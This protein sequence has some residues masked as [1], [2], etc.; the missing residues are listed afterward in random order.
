MKSRFILHTA[1]F[2]LLTSW[3]FLLPV[4][5]AD[6]QEKETLPDLLALKDKKA[7]DS[8]TPL[9]S[10]GLDDANKPNGRIYR[11]RVSI[12]DSPPAFIK[13]M[14]Q[15]MTLVIADQ[16]G[17]GGYFCLY[18]GP[19]SEDWT[20]CDYLAVL[21]DAAGKAVWETSLDP[22]LSSPVYL[23]IQDIRY[24]DGKLYF[25]EACISY[26]EQVEGA[27]SS[28]VC[29]DP[30][31][32]RVL[33]RTPNLVSNNVFILHGPLIICGYGFTQEADF[34]YL[35]KSDTGEVIS[36]T[37]LA[38]AHDY[39]AVRDNT[40]YATTYNQLYTFELPDLSGL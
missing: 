18:K 28:L 4:S 25:N 39:L 36:Q 15:G 7:I 9:A 3:L 1:L 38:T 33:W 22:F 19:Y 34:L 27:C 8:T 23:E 5:G 24:A 29:L 26:A 31:A 32:Q 12:P 11:L 2:L 13:Q 21:F 6:A 35:V 30:V 20:N 14:R 10:L 40:L 17:D 16:T 37:S